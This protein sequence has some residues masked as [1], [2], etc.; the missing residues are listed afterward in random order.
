MRFE[1]RPIVGR[2]TLLSALVKAYK[3]RHRLEPD[4]VSGSF[5]YPAVLEHG[6]H[7]DCTMGADYLASD[8]TSTRL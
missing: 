7:V 4:L 2:I 1:Q 6:F 3:P 8:E 5:V